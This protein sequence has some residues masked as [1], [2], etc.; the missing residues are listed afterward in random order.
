MAS[1]TK[2]WKTAP[3]YMR[4]F[5]DDFDLSVWDAAAIMGNAGY[6][7]GGLVQLQEIN[8]VVK[9]S[10]GGTGLFMWTGERRKAFEAYCQRNDLDPASDKANYGWAFVELK[11]TESRAKAA[12]LGASTLRDKVIA[13]ERT[14]ERAG[15]K[16]YDKRVEWAEYA[17]KAYRAA[18]PEAVA[19]GSGVAVISGS[20]AYT[21]EDG[22][23][24]VIELL[25]RQKH[26]A[27]ISV[28]FEK[29]S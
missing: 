16:N 26:V 10:R 21:P 11:S 7:S 20:G 9:G 8:P 19:Q 5:M 4:L 17:L 25:L 6:E 22:M 29:K 13:F 12:L 24:D 28:T 18:Y 1:S 3:K 23:S 14:F 15:V 27:S 2:F